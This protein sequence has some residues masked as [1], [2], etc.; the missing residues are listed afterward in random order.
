MHVSVNMHT[1]ICA[2]FSQSLSLFSSFPPLAPTVR[3]LWYSRISRT[4]G[5]IFSTAQAL[6]NLLIFFCSPLIALPY[7]AM[8]FSR[9]DLSDRF[10]LG[11]ARHCRLRDCVCVCIY[12][13][14]CGLQEDCR[15]WDER[16]SS[17]ILMQF[18]VLGNHLLDI[19]ISLRVCFAN[20]C[21]KFNQ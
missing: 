14:M 21:V 15:V 1:V 2:S 12:V 10:W 6:S 13:C 8:V 17:F 9:I 3:I 16:R 7:I 18:L 5:A 19:L 20:D 4:R 11:S